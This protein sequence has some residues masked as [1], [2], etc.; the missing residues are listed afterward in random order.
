MPPGLVRQ[1]L[2]PKQIELFRQWIDQGAKWQS[3]WAFDP[4]KRSAIP[5]VKDKPGRRIPSTISRWRVW[6]ARG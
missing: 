3:H 1:S 6:K 4:P 5:E 2:T